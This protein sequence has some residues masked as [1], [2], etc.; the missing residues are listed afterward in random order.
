MFSNTGGLI[1]HKD[2]T[3]QVNFIRIFFVFIVILLGGCSRNTVPTQGEIAPEEPEPTPIQTLSVP[4]NPEEEIDE[5]LILRLWLPPEMDPSSG[6]QAGELLRAR[7][8]EFLVRHPEASIQFRIKAPTGPGGVLESLDA[9][10][11]VAPNALPDLVALQRSNLEAGVG[12]ALLYP[13]SEFEAIQ[14]DTDWYEFA[15]NLARVN[16]TPYGISFAN[17][18]LA[19]LYRPEVIGDPPKD[20]STTQQLSTALFFPAGSPQSLFTLAL[21]QAAGGNIEIQQG[22]LTINTATLAAV[23]KFFDDA[24]SNGI[25]SESLAEFNSEDEAFEAYKDHQSELVITWVSNYL[26]EPMDDTAVAGLP[27]PGGVPFTYAIGWSWALSKPDSNHQEL[28]AELAS[29]LTES[30]FLSKWTFAAG[31]LPPRPSALALW[32]ESSQSSLAS[33]IVLSSKIIPRSDVVDKIG[34]ALRISTIDIL[35]GE[36]GTVEAAESVAERLGS[37]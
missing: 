5:P 37:P 17:D 12:M 6:T 15:Q 20:W 1:I 4:N 34:P 25:M 16:N 31:Y 27:T 8:E 13:L 26:S 32:P 23:F 19:M 22:G 9:T 28:S 18:A 29:F 7:F 14:N 33:R 21:Y 3:F 24:R 11:I 35:R 36:V 10:R 30:E 2:S